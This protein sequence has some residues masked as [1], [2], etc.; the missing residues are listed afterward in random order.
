MSIEKQLFE[1]AKSLIELRYPNGWGGAAAMYSLNGNIYTSIAP[2]VINASTNL[3][4]ETGAILEAHKNNDP[5]THTICVVRDDEQ[6]QFKILTTCGTCQERLKYW[7]SEIKA[8]V[9]DKNFTLTFVTLKE[10]QP[11]HW[12]QAYYD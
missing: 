7:G 8:A 12:S 3:C 11:Y 6:S 10:L 9:T 4:I 1:A 2:E 5:I